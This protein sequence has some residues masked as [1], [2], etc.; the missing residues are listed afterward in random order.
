MNT[1]TT[2]VKVIERQLV[3]YV[4]SNTDTTEGRGAS[5]VIGRYI[6][7]NEAINA[8]KGKGV[9]GTD[10]K[11]ESSFHPMIR[12]GKKLYLLGA[13]VTPLT[14]EEEKRQALREQALSKLS[15]EEKEALG[16]S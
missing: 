14:T 10:A 3:Y 13:E 12:V 8:A 6:D 4:V 15:E 1:H 11:V 2:D 16:V 9:F 5:V 7:N